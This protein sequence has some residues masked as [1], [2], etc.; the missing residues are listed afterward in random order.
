MPRYKTGAAARAAAARYSAKFD[1]VMIRLPKGAAEEIR[2]RTG[3][4]CAA[5]FIE[6]YAAD[7]E[8]TGRTPAASPEDQATPGPEEDR[9]E[10]PF[11]ED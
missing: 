7:L 10:L 8:R 11:P 6:L 3:K 1:K 5:Y 4:S 2:Q 9:E